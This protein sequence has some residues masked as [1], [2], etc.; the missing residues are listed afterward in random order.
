MG[1]VEPETHFK[2]YWLKCEMELAVIMELS[3]GTYFWPAASHDRGPKVRKNLPRRR[4][5]E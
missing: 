3:R 1:P 5:L 4:L 2:P